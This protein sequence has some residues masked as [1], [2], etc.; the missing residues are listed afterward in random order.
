MKNK[1]QIT[2]EMLEI[3][4]N[5]TYE[6]TSILPTRENTGYKKYGNCPAVVVSIDIRNFK[7]YQEKYRSQWVVKTLQCFTR[8]LTEYAK[9][10]YFAQYFRD[11]YYAGDEVLVVFEGSKKNGISLAF[12]YAIYANSLINKILAKAL[13]EAGLTGWDFR[14]GIGVWSSNDN[15]LTMVGQKYSSIDSTTTLIGSSINWASYIAK[16]G[17]KNG[18]K[19]ILLNFDVANN[20]IDDQKESFDKWCKKYSQVNNEWVYECNIIKTN[21]V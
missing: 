16:L 1:E 3:L 9:D 5:K 18:V 2:K 15:T 6:E 14:A 4:N 7:K 19:P 21:L 12:E 17:N 13:K 20:L 10:S 11:V 8:I